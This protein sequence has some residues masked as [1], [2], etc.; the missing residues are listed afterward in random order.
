MHHGK[1]VCEDERWTVQSHDKALVVL[2]P[3]LI[4]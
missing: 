1:T 2:L 3:L 4:K